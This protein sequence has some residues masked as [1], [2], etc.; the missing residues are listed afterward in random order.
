MEK[1]ARKQVDI[2][3]VKIDSTELVE[4]LKYVGSRLKKF[5]SEAVTKEKFYIVT[6]NPEQIMRA[7]NDT[8]FTEILNNSDI[9]LPDGIGLVAA[10]KF[11]SLPTTNSYLLKPILYFAQGLGV[12]FSII[13]D[14]KWLEADLKAIQGRRIFIDLIQLANQNG[15]KVF[16]LG[17]RQKS[18]QKA[19]AVLSENYK[20]VHLVG[21]A[22][23]N[24]D[25]D[26]NPKSRQDKEIE[27]KVVKKIQEEKPHLL[28]IG[29]GAPKQEKW[30]YRWYNKLEI[31]GAMVVG[32]TFD[33]ISGKAKLP[34]N[35]IATL[36]LE[37][38]WRIL[39][40]SQKWER[41][42]VAVI[43][44]PLKVFWEKILKI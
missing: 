11:L 2:L 34:P 8:V 28:F 9:S 1:R 41:V 4:V 35:W 36:G 14:R 42:K 31:G 22:G 10:H 26:A 33:Y 16:L 19:L 40:G 39:T 23:P 25:D 27:E 13:F 20:R 30:L 43:D 37:W 21:I 5:T 38:L 7:S 32:V 44:F 24:L 3:G 6:P 17:D 15:W 18:A 12:G 29:F